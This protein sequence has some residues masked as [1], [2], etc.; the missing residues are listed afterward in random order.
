MGG[1]QAGEAQAGIL[2]PV[3]PQARYLEFSATVRPLCAGALQAP[4]ELADGPRVVVALS[5]S[6]LQ[7]LGRKI[8]RLRCFGGAAG[9]GI[10]APATPAAPWF[11]MRSEALMRRM[12]GTE[13]AVADALFGFTRPVSGAYVWC[14]PMHQGRLDLRALTP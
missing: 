5:L 11:R 6:L 1:V 8:E 14:P 7:L 12:I 2:A 13:D 3:P 10:E 9:P 4:R